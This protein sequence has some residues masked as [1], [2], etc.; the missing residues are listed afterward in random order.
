MEAKQVAHE[1]EASGST[2]ILKNKTHEIA[3]FYFQNK[4]SCN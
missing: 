3:T 2:A 1:M 4:N